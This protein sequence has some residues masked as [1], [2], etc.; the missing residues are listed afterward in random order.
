MRI[1]AADELPPPIR[2]GFVINM[3][4]PERA[5]PVNVNNNR[6]FIPNDPLHRWD[7]KHIIM[8]MAL[9]FLLL[10]IYN[11]IDHY[12]INNEKKKRRY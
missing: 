9:L 4:P 12:L 6:D 8:W 2:D 10:I 1:G 7:M 5:M 3:D 11:I